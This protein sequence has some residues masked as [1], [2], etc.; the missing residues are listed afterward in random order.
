[1]VG[2]SGAGKSTLVNLL[3]RFWDYAAPGNA[4]QI[5]LNGQELAC[6]R[7]EEV[8]SMLAV[9]SQNTY[10]FNATLRENLLIARPQASES[11]I[12]RAVAQAQLEALI[13]RLPQGLDTWIGEG[14]LRLSAG[15]RQRVAIARAI[16]RDAPLLILDEATAN[17]D[18]M[19]EREV[20]G[21]IHTLMEGRS[22]L[23]IT[24]RLVSMEWMDEILVLRGGRVA[25]RGRHQDLIQQ[26]GWYAR[27]WRQQQ[28]LIAQDQ[29][30]N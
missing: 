17:L 9:V 19:T 15:E 7:P 16:L 12:L 11:E 2:P 13:E 8:R 24:H 10:L 1:V 3:L 27:M 29:K 22:T 18:T 21:A 26:G 14:G 20:L 23:M 30:I 5:L 4:G 6:Y 25:E 28:S